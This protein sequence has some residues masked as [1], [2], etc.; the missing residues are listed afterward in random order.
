MLETCSFADG[1]PGYRVGSFTPPATLW[2]TGCTRS[3]TV[4]NSHPRRLV[5]LPSR[6]D[7][8]TLQ[9]FD[10]Q[11]EEKTMKIV[12]L[13]GYTLNPGDNPWTPVEKLG[14]LTVYDRTPADQVVERSKDAEIILT[15]KTPITRETLKQ[16]PKLQ[17]ISVLATGY[18]IVDTQAA[19]E[20]NIPVS[21][22]PVYGTDSVAE[23]T[24]ALITSHFRR[25]VLHDELVRK[26]EWRKSGDFSFWR[27]PLQELAGKT[28]GIVGFGRIG[29]RVGDLAAAFKMRVLAH[30]EYRQNPP[31]YDFAWRQPEELFAESDVVT[32]HCNQT[33]EN[34]GMVNKDLLSRMKKTAFFVNTARGGLVNE[35]DLAQALKDGQLAGAAVDVVS[36]E[37]IT[38]DNPLLTAPNILITPHIAWAACEARVRLMQ[39]T[40]E[41]I[42]KFQA[43]EPINQVN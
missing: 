33:P 37:P 39:I 28:I 4:A 31:S 5:R 11:L 23:Y 6:R 18:N 38:D 27:A 42:V 43:G 7:E 12:V 34:T 22:V 19:R 32:L 1:L 3:A 35:A 14:E 2:H 30:D 15:N 36:Q 24:F 25:P 17:F 9:G 26:G 29:R 41:N 10:T 20:R 16:L 8:D 21:N 13:D 40:A